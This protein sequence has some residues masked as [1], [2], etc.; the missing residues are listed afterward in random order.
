MSD[1]SH[2]F[3]DFAPRRSAD[4]TADGRLARNGTNF[5]LK[6][7]H[8]LLLQVLGL[9]HAEAPAPI[10]VLRDRLAQGLKAF[11]R[12]AERHAID[13]D[14]LASAS[15]CLC[16]FLDEM[17][18]ATSWGS[19]GAW[20]NRSLLVM[21]HG[22]ASGGERFFSILTKLSQRPG[23]TIDALEL[24]AVLLALGMEGRY[25][26]VDSGREELA[27]I[28]R[29]LQQLI[30]KTRP[31]HPPALSDPWETG[32][33]RRSIPVMP[34]ITA[35][36]F[37]AW[38]LLYAC[39]H[40]RL[41]R[42]ADRELDA[43]MHLPRERSAESEAAPLLPA[44]EQ[45]LKALLASDMATGI[46]D[47]DTKA[48]RATITWQSDAL[49][50]SGSAAVLPAHQ[51]HVRRLS[52]LLR[53]V[54]GRIMVIGY[55][56]NQPLR[57]ASASNWQLSIA[58]ANSI[59]ALLRTNEDPPDRYLIQGRGDTEPVASNDTAEGRARNRRVTLTLLAPGATF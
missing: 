31:D 56:D 54:P 35:G 51:Q 21:F 58:R 7:A 9:R 2:V 41:H 5:L 16:T 47:V 33:L 36:L 15:Y 12:G 29:Q 34:W 49:F 24:L 40:V 48:D 20:A 19:D 50:A 18:A 38:L 28:Q 23:E 53:E 44:W 10:E 55:T 6:L 14:T 27:H 22:E 39:L 37:G 3:T 42:M 59:A 45:R 1:S 43:Y 32:A 46:V 30:R 57:S 13:K 17:I 26:L 25:R 8:P 52:Q 4:E 11:H